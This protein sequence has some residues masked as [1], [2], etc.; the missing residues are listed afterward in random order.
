MGNSSKGT[1]NLTTLLF[2]P[3]RWWWC[4]GNFRCIFEAVKYMRLDAR[5][6]YLLSSC[7]SAVCHR[8]FYKPFV[9]AFST[10][11][12]SYNLWAPYS[13]MSSHFW[14]MSSNLSEEW[15]NAKDLCNK[16]PDKSVSICTHLFTELLLCIAMRDAFL[17]VLSGALPCIASTCGLTGN[18]QI[19]PAGTHW[20]WNLLT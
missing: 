10:T 19:H 6:P 5:V 11:G 18:C 14:A 7:R 12:D 16:L 8:T 9:R 13:H 15:A 17:R 1:S 20:P 4:I 3:R 2:I